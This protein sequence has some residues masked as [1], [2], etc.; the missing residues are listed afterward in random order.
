MIKGM[1]SLYLLNPLSPPGRGLEWIREVLCLTCDFTFA[2]LH[3][4]DRVDG[5]PVVADHV[6]ANP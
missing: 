5:P 1:I 4:A 2:E 6:L 3:D